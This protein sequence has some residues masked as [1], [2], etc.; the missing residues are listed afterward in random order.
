MAVLNLLVAYEREEGRLAF[1]QW[2]LLAFIFPGLS[3]DEALSIHEKLRNFVAAEMRTGA[4]RFAWVLPAGML[5]LAGLALYIPFILS[6]PPRPRILLIASVPV[7]LS[8]A[9]GMEMIGG[10]LEEAN[11]V[12]SWATAWPPAWRRQWRDSASGAI[13]IRI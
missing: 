6:F 7:F 10:I 11:G 13:S 3:A 9:I 2:L 1:L 8:G 4:L 5:C 12:H